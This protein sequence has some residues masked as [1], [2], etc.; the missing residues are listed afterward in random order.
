MFIRQQLIRA[1]S[2]IFACTLFFSQATTA[3]EQR[4][5]STD[6][7]ATALVLSMGY[8]KDLVAIDVTSQV[9][10]EYKGLPNIGYHR[11]LSAEGLLSLAPTLVV[12]SEHMGPP[13]VIAALQGADIDLVRLPVAQD[14]DTLANNIQQVGQALGDSKGSQSLQEILQNQQNELQQGK[15]TQDVEM[16]FLLD[17][18]AEQLRMAGSGTGGEAFIKLLGGTNLAE[19]KNYQTVSE[20]SLLA[21]QPQVILVA[22]HGATENKNMRFSEAILTA[23]PAGIN[24]Q[25]LAVDGSTLVAGLSLAAIV[26]ALK[27]QREIN[28]ANQVAELQ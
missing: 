21:M 13:P 6:A 9:P 27:V 4:I 10:A 1:A 15:P 5:I 26:E 18:G 11:N 19:F 28:T 7:G 22:S 8:G 25:I 24:K 14:I 17:V 3:D 23:T 16:I 2:A 12:G 20:E